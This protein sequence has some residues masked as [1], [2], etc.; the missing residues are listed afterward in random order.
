M[1]EILWFFAFFGA[2]AI[3]ARLAGGLGATTG[4]SD[5]MPWGMWKILNMVAGVALGTGGFVVAAVVY[6]F[7]MEKFKSLSKP[8]IL[9]A[10]LGYGSSCFALFLDIGLPLAIWKPIVFW[11]PHS[12]LF[13][14]SW[15]VMLYFSVTIIETAPV[16]LEKFKLTRLVHLL[17]KISIP[18]VIFGVTLSTLHHSSLGS[19]FLTMPARLHPLWFT[20]WLPLLFIVSAIGAGLQMLILVSL[21]Y[22]YFYRRPVNMPV[23]T[24]VANGSA[25]F[26]SLYLVLK[27]ADLLIRSRSG[28]A[29]S[30]QWETG[31]YSLEVIFGCLIPILL[32]TTPSLRNRPGWLAIAASSA[33]C[34][35]ILNR[36]N[37]GIIGLIR[38]ADQAYVPTLI[39]WSVSLGVVSMAALVFIFMVEYF[40]IFEGMAIR[41]RQIL[42]SKEETP[43]RLLEGVGAYR[44]MSTFVRVTLLATITI[45]LAVVLFAN[46]ALAGIALQSE[47]IRPP[48]GVDQ[49]RATLLIDGNRN[50]QSVKFPHQ[51]HK[52]NQGGDQS[53]QTCHHM[54]MPGDKSSSCSECHADMW[55]PKSIFNHENHVA[56]LGDKWSC[57]ECHDSHVAK[58][59]LNS[60]DCSEC[61]VEMDIKLSTEGQPDFIADSYMDAMHGLC[62]D[63]HQQHDQRKGEQKMAECAFCHDAPQIQ[64]SEIDKA[65]RSRSEGQ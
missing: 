47:S 15:C 63:C 56:A 32:I 36:L 17:H 60:K 7:K 28:I 21:G 64:M 27:L 58:D 61:H 44:S 52:D 5:S 33:V 6:I 50:T 62:L 25:V 24:S 41:D 4:L 10:L 26:L 12:F 9:I 20:S 53:C 38:T 3:V 34:G 57:R 48:V 40:P 1:K 8:A 51:A 13:E 31:F 42:R 46:Q 30:F 49:T 23:L 65:S 55:Q 11:N 39:E 45:P 22:S 54:D 35:L 14:V 16:I 18:I 2:V 37:V 43:I 59:I 19:L 29:F